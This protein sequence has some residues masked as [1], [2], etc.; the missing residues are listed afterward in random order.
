M[1][2]ENTTM[3][4]NELKA[5]IDRA[6]YQVDVDAV[7]EAFVSRMVAVHGALRRADVRALLGD[8]ALKELRV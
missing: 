1:D 4:I 5:Q 8:A 3:R 2:D 6:A 7:A